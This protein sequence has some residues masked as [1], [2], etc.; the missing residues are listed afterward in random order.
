MSTQ[1]VLPDVGRLPLLPMRTYGG[2]KQNHADVSG[3]ADV[4]RGLA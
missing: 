3:L 1:C 4:Y 2:E